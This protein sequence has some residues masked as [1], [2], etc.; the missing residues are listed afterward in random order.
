MWKQILVIEFILNLHIHPLPAD[1]QTKIATSHEEMGWET[2][3]EDWRRRRTTC[4]EQLV[5]ECC[6][7][8]WNGDKR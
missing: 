5:M 7:Y 6:T 2:E 8:I 4:M 1:V 3:E